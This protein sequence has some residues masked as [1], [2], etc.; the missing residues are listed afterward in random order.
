M[1][2]IDRLTAILIQLQ[3]KK[4]VKA[5]EI[6]DR[7]HISLRTVYRDVRALEEAGVPIGAEAGVGY[8]LSEGYQ[9]PPV[10]FSKSEAAALLTGE[11]LL[12]KLGDK[13]VGEHFS[14]AMQ[15]I[16]AVLRLKEKEYLETL[17]KSLSVHRFTPKISEQ[18]PNNFLSDVQESIGSKRVLEMEYFS[19]YNE[20]ITTRKIEPLG[21]CYIS[22]RWHLIAWCRLRQDYRDFRLDR[23]KGLHISDEK[24][25]PR[26]HTSLQDYLRQVTKREQTMK[27]VVE[28]ETSVAK[29]LH[30][31][32][33]YYGWVDEFAS[34][35]KIQMTF[36]GC[37]SL[38]YFCRWLLL[39]GN[40][41]EIIEPESLQDRM[42]QLTEEVYL[43]Y[44]KTPVIATNANVDYR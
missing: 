7:F 32:K 31:Q 18:F 11:K 29:Y 27:F 1:N 25:A 28:F 17:E 14:N 43:H 12:A 36:L 41:V 24:Y 10:M 20:Q 15:K 40:A 23:I 39:C 34:G 30:E 13:S 5:Q 22:N 8:F 2:R 9:L 6:A 35:D 26:R 4:V 33:F 19:Q 16:R 3:T 42:Q 37:S 44:R 21:I 38:D